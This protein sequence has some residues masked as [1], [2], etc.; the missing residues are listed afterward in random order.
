LSKTSFLRGQQCAKALFLYKYYPHLRDPMPPERLAVLRRGNEVGELARKLF[1]GGIDASAGASPRSMDAVV[2]TK[3]LIE[4]GTKIIY[5][6]SFV[7]NE[8]LV[9][10]DVLAF[11][12]GEWNMY[13]VKSSLRLSQSNI[14]DASLQFAVVRGTGLDVRRVFLVNLNG[15]YKRRGAINLKELFNV[16]E[17]TSD[18]F[19]LENDLM[20]AAEE[21]KLIL[22]MPQA[23]EIKIGAQC[24]TPYECDFRGQCWKNTGDFSPFKLSGT[25]RSEQGRLYAEGCLDYRNLSGEEKRNLSRLTYLQVVTAQKNSIHLDKESIRSYL[26]KAGEEIMFVD[27]ESFQPAVPV[28]EGTSPFMQLPF[29]FSVHHL[30]KSGELKHYVFIAEPGEDPRKQFTEEFIRATEGHCTIMAYDM[31]AENGILN[32]MKKLFPEY[33]SDI[34]SRIAR[35]ADLMK[36]FS[37]GWYHHPSMMGSISL[38]YV[39][40][41]LVPELNYDNLKIRNGSHAMTVYE[42]L[43]KENDLFARAEKLDALREYSTLDTLGMVR[44]FEVLVTASGGNN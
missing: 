25:S 29:A 38:K 16:T 44:I 14:N 21:Q 31:T 19:R 42:G 18:A 15:Y 27:I 6:A 39:L 5:E 35:T 36:P 3:E 34:D 20:K 12:E 9:M 40:P 7:H 17:I 4:A 10:I 22:G 28:Y 23:P 30:L 8:I 32:Q 2:R 43:T 24:Y 37:E 11:E 1:P 33:R 26:Q 41:A 13:E